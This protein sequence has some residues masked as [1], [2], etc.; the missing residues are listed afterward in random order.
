MDLTRL[1][2]VALVSYGAA[3][4]SYKFLVELCPERQELVPHAQRTWE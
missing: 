4:R 1:N 2:D 3:C